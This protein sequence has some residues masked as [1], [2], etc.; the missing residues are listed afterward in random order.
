M[1]ETWVWSL[2][3]EGSLE[4]GVVTH[5]SILAWRIPWTGKSGGLQ[6]MGSQRVGHDWVIN[7]HMLS[8][9]FLVSFL[10]FSCCGCR[11]FC[12]L[13]L[14][15][16]KTGFF[17]WVSVILCDWKLLK[18]ENYPVLVHS[19][20]CGCLLWVIIWYLH[21]VASF[22]LPRVSSYLWGSWS[23]GSSSVTA[24]EQPCF[25]SWLRHLPYDL[26]TTFCISVLLFVKW[27]CQYQLCKVKYVQ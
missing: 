5:S 22:I 26:V 27:E 8:G 20:I 18:E 3:Q 2:D 24:E 1:Q 23:D 17:I 25:R 11:N 9:Y 19:S 15:V 14:S 4:E 16:S 13:G 10:T 6:S 21:V 7:T 12:P